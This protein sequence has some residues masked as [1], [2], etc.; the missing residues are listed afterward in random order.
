MGAHPLLELRLGGLGAGLEHDGGDDLL[1]PLVVGH[2]DDCGLGD[3]RVADEHVLDLA[4]RQVLGATHDDVVEAPLEEE[5]AVVVE[6]T[7]RRWW[8]TSRRR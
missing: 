7:R 4:R 1:A 2:A 8:G 3:G 6:V 5:V